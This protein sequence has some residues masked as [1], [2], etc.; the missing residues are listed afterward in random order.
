MI[1]ESIFCYSYCLSLTLFVCLLWHM[2]CVC[3]WCGTLTSFHECPGSSMFC[4]YS[5]HNAVS[6]FTN[7]TFYLKTLHHVDSS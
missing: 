7:E 3:V 4:F 1:C 6:D 2:W 5:L